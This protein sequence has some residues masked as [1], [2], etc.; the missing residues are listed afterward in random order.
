MELYKLSAKEVIRRISNGELLAREYV[1]SI[2]ERIKQLNYKINAYITVF[3]DYALKRAE[4]I[5][6]KAKKGKVGKLA[7]VAVA[8]KDNICVKNFPTTCASRMLKDFNPPYNAT[9]IERI[10]CEDGIIIGKTNM[11]EFAMGSSNENS[12]YGP[13]RNPWDLSRVSGGSS[14]GSCAAV[15]AF[16]ATVALGSD[17]GGSIRCP[18]S[19]CSVVGLKPTYGLVSR[20]GL[21][22]Y[23]SSLDQIGPIARDVYDCALLLSIISGH[24]SMDSTSLPYEKK[25]YTRSLDEFPENVRLALVKEMTENGVD[26]DIKRVIKESVHTFESLGVEI[27]EVN[28]PN[29]KYALPAYYIIAMAEASS[30]LARY[31]AIRYG[32]AIA[33]HESWEEYIMVSRGKAL[34]QEVKRRIILGSFV[35]SAG[36]YE[37]YYIK[38]LKVRRLIKESFDKAFEKYDILMGPTMPILPFKIGE[39]IQNPLELYMCDINTVPVNLA[40]LPSLSLPCAFVGGLP[41]GL[42]MISKPLQEELIL[43]VAYAFEKKAKIN[44]NFPKL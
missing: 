40:G 5:D 35:L 32:S 28:I 41:V 1:E 37:Q 14:G 26:S 19:F 10:L 16:L 13:V 4:E 8:V 18:A 3:E 22:A 6:R 7:G 12:Y 27:G 23:A 34:G 24:D 42:Q 11:D 33:D 43:R 20:Y 29:L 44:E 39:K 15:S 31:D 36:Y 30:N 38:A 17:T 9:V 21:I 2:L 25:D